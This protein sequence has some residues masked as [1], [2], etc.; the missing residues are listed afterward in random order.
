MDVDGY[1]LKDEVRQLTVVSGI[2]KAEAAELKKQLQKIK[3]IAID[4]NLTSKESRSQIVE[5][6]KHNL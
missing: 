2:R 3:E 6:L 1:I 4:I 5:I